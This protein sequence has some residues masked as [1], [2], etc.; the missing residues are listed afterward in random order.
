MRV[1]YSLLSSVAIGVGVFLTGIS[2]IMYL[3]E[4]VCRTQ[5][6]AMSTGEELQLIPA[7]VI[8]QGWCVCITTRIP[9]MR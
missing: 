3:L 4:R 9:V 7:D 8:A 1:L 6:L 2:A 5:V